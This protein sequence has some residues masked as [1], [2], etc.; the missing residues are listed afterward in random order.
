M[1]L[2]DLIGRRRICRRSG[3][4]KNKKRYPSKLVSDLALHFFYSVAQIL[5]SLRR[6][7]VKNNCFVALF[8]VDK[9]SYKHIVFW[10]IHGHFSP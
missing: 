4:L 3:I 1:A 2:T 6:R 10:I 9:S 8:G 7:V 5:A